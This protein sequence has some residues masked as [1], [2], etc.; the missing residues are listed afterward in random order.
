[1]LTDAARIVRFWQ[2]V[3]TVNPRPLP[4]PDFRENVTDVRGEDLLPWEAGSRFAARQPTVGQVWRHQVFGGLFELTALRAALAG[5]YGG[6]DPNGEP[7]GS[8]DALSGAAQGQSA[9]FAC[10]VDEA[11][12]LIGRAEVSGCASALGRAAVAG[13]DPAAWLSALEQDASADWAGALPARPLTGTDLRRF[14]VELAERLGVAA[15]LAPAGLRVRSYLVSD[16]AASGE[17]DPQAY[18]LGS[19]F[20]HDLALVAGALSGRDAGAGG[21]GG[22][23]PALADYLCS[24]EEISWASRVDVRREPLEVRDGCAP[25]RIP[26]GRWVADTGHALVRSQ[27]FAVNQIVARLTPGPGLFAVHAAPGTGATAVF[28]D[29]IATIV[30]ERARRLAELPTTLAAFGSSLTWQAGQTIHTVTAP[31]PSLTGF[32]VLLAGPDDNDTTIGDISGRWSDRASEVDYFASTARLACGG[33]AWGLIAARLGDR[34]ER[35]GFVERFWE[36]TVRGTDALFRVGEAMPDFLGRAAAPDWPSAVDSFSEAMA[37][38]NALS[39]ERTVASASIARLSAVEETLEGAYLLLETAQARRAELAEREARAAGEQAAAEARQR[40]AL[41]DL[42]AHVADRPGLLAGLRASREWQARR[43]DLRVAYE[44]AVDGRATAI[45]QT[46]SVRADLAAAR[47][48]VTE[49]E[50]EVGV[51]TA[52]MA[53]LQEPVAQVR[54]RWGNHVPDGPS[55]EETEDAALIERREQ[56]ASWADEEF[57]A[58][59]T[60]LFLAALALHKALIAA[61]ADTF[62]RNL[63]ALMDMLSEDAPVPAE[64]ALAAWQSF[65]LV[66]PVVS[67]TFAS[68]G[69]LFAG[70]GRG[71]IGWL[72]A[73]QAGLVPPQ[74]VLGALWRADR[75][76]FAGDSLQAIPETPLPWRGQQALLKTL[77]VDEEWAPAR[78]CAQR[79][80]DRLA[81]YGTWLPVEA[82]DGSGRLWVGTPLRVHRRSDRAIVEVCNEIAYD[83]LLVCGTPMRETFPGSDTWF[84]VRPGAGGAGHRPSGPWIPAE[85]EALLSLLTSLRVAGVPAAEVRVVSPFGAVAVAAARVYCSVFGEVSADELRSRVGTVHTVREG[86]VVVLMLGGDPS[87]PDARVFASQAPNLLNSAIGR[88]RRRLY[89]IGNRELW[90]T[91]PYFDVLARRLAETEATPA[92][93]VWGPRRN[94]AG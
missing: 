23:G 90:E 71:S 50:D 40:K 62:E 22:A 49:A 52:D 84:D 33:G 58:A 67:T 17:C 81:R 76:V 46:Q 14:A 59:R 2:A 89:V 44:E 47:R 68:V 28:S 72:L 80:A 13:G 39:S 36:G 56:T 85:G 92:E 51:L 64:V 73:D 70:L 38:V 9:L 43:I 7:G 88:A 11:G 57:N 3:E 86:D 31:M 15:L 66:M 32:E 45:A 19:P 82:P 10:T 25:Q 37:K 34:S 87:R 77:E 74:Q 69:S 93:R 1:M 91:Q 29:L 42:D 75:A 54:R 20:A 55:Q 63:G 16:G 24:G 60:E 21:A 78:S 8:P 48:S 5:L 18:P 83:G 27:Q 26:L 41:A 94:L 4:R 65:F 6:A 30:V 79:V 12:V 53:A 61:E 35:R